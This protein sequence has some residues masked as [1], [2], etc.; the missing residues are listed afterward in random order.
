MITGKI[1]K[2]AAPEENIAILYETVKKTASHWYSLMRSLSIAQRCSLFVAPVVSLA[3]NQKK[4]KVVECLGK[5]VKGSDV[6][7]CPVMISGFKI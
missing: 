2:M 3:C 7:D 6:R 5:G 1:Q 4:I